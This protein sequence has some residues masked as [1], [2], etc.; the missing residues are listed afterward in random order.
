MKRPEATGPT[1]PVLLTPRLELRGHLEED[2][3]D[4]AAMWA[5][6]EVTRYVGGRPFTEEEVWARILRY[7]GHWAMTGFGYWAIV[8][9]ESGRFVG[10]AGLGDGRR[11][12]DPPWGRT[13]EVGWALARRA[14]GKGLATEAVR[15]VLAWADANLPESRTV[16]M[17]EPANLASLRVADKLGYCMYARSSYAGE[18][19]VLLERG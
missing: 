8:E 3:P 11:A 14:Q 16:C 12:I 19:M 18:S 4:C 1:V 2:L 5:D 13:P 17:I 7:V 6:P 15:A 9:R 10:E